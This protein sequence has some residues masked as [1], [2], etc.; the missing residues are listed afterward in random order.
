[1]LHSKLVQILHI[2]KNTC[3]SFSYELS[4]CTHRSLQWT[5]QVWSLCLVG[6]LPLVALQKNTFTFSGIRSLQIFIQ[7]SSILS[8]L[9]STKLSMVQWYA[10][11][12][13]PMGCKF[14]TLF[15]FSHL[16]HNWH[17]I[18]SRHFSHWKPPW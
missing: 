12:V 4:Q 3:Q 1:M 7:L 15:I 9:L 17:G 16:I 11:C 6:R 14:P 18:Y 10:D 5:P 2:R 13:V 8:S